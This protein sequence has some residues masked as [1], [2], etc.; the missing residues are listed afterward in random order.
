MFY[1]SQANK[2][3]QMAI[4]KVHLPPGFSLDILKKEKIKDAVIIELK[5]D[6]QFSPEVRTGHCVSFQVLPICLPSATGGTS[7]NDYQEQV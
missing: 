2:T 4:L 6:V 7:G 1:S 3:Q 5:K